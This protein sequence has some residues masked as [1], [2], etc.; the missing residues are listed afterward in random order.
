VFH[1]RRNEALELPEQPRRA[2]VPDHFLTL[3]HA[4]VATPVAHADLQFRPTNLR[5]EEHGLP[6][7]DPLVGKTKPNFGREIHGAAANPVVFATGFQAPD[8][9]VVDL[10][11]YLVRNVFRLR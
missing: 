1:E 9:V 6:S 5:A 10:L 7:L 4:Q 8:V 3:D 2:C 11:K